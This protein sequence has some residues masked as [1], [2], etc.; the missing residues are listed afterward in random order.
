MDDDR[1]ENGASSELPEDI[2]R[3]T[4]KRRAALV[5]PIL[6]GETTAVETAP[7][8][9]LTA[10]L[11]V[12]GPETRVRSGCRNLRYLAMRIRVV[13]VEHTGEHLT[14]GARPQ[15]TSEQRPQRPYGP[16]S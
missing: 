13:F 4:A 3:R 7:K 11:V 6:K 15:A 5:L 14:H 16:R 9:G 8:H 2:Q 12:P 1:D 10:I